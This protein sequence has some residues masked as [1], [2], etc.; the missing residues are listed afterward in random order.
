MSARSF[1]PARLIAAATIAI[2]AFSL[3]ACDGDS[4]AAG[5]SS[6]HSSH[7]VAIKPVGEARDAGK[8]NSVG[9]KANSQPGRSGEQQSTGAASGGSSRNNGSGSAGSGSG[10]SDG[11]IACD[12]GN[13]RTTAQEVKEPLN[14]MLITVTNVS[15]KP[16]DLYYHP[17]L[18]FGD[19]ATTPPVIEDSQPQAV[20]TLNPGDSGYAGVILSAADGSGV[21]GENEHS[22]TVSFS[23]INA[24]ELPSVARPAL[25]A[26]GVYVDS[27]VRV[28]Y[29]QFSLQD[30]L[31]Y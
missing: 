2:A 9:D 18:V 27:S 16:C 25:P 22:L 19:G 1:R 4:D 30:A 29:W 15:E 3:T 12:G 20:V 24:K 7:A 8:A 14:H 6:S 31:T 5:G 28:T 26:K 17:G 21:N 23:D 10:G 13:T 11:R